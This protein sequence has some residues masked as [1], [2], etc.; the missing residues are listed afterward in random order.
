MVA[1]GGMVT[2]EKIDWSECS[3]VEVKPE[4]QSGAPVLRGTRMPV[5][6]IVDNFDYGVSVAEIAEQFEVPLDRIEAILAYAKSHRIAHP[7]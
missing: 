6:A 2:K 7:V 3:L 1:E 5:N 4:V